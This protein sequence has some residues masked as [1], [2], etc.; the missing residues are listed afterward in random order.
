MADV[1]GRRRV[2]CGALLLMV[3]GC[4]VAALA[5]NIEMPFAGRVNAGIAGFRQVS[6]R[7]EKPTPGDPLIAS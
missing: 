6:G 5:S 2:L 4:A 3:A 7:Q 1:A